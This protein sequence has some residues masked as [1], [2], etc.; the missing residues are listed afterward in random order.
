VGKY[1]SASAQGGA[2]ALPGLS[3]RSRPGW[4]DG[5]VIAEVRSLGGLLSVYNTECRSILSRQKKEVEKLD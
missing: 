3:R 5:A 4:A 2:V 1:L